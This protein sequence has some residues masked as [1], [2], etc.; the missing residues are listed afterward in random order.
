MN[1]DTEREGGEREREGEGERWR[2]R[3]RERGSLFGL[4]EVAVRILK[5]CAKGGGKRA[6]MKQI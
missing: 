4:R 3:E 2:E 1:E 6:N 5:K